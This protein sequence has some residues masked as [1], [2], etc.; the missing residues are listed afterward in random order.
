MAEWPSV[1][2]P[3]STS[4]GSQ[5]PLLVG[6]DDELTLIRS[7]LGSG[8]GSKHFGTLLVGQRGYGKTVILGKM[9]AEAIEHDW[10]VIEVNCSTGTALAEIEARARSIL[11]HHYGSLMGRIAARIKGGGISVL[12]TGAYVDIDLSEGGVTSFSDLLVTLGAAAK[13]KSQGVLLL[14]DEMHSLASQ[15]M[16]VLAATLQHVTNSLDYPV[17]YIGAGLPQLAE[18]IID[19]DAI[20]FFHRC[21]RL[22]LG[23]LADC[24]VAEGLSIPI[25]RYGGELTDRALEESVAYV[26]G[27]PYKLQMLGHHLWHVSAGV[28]HKITEEHLEVAKNRVD[29]ELD[30]HIYATI[31]KLVS[32]PGRNFVQAVLQ[33]GAT[34][35]LQDVQRLMKVAMND[36]NECKNELASHGL[37]EHDNGDWVSLTDLIPHNVLLRYLA[38]RPTPNREFAYSTAT[39]ES[40]SMRLAALSSAPPPVSTDLVCGLWMPRSRTYCVLPNGHKGRCRSHTP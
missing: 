23:A 21:D 22:V 24:D 5:P 38:R 10:P 36:V 25:A 18:I 31:W 40:A 30:K 28:E 27:Y 17:A 16:R 20:S 8:P 19:D 11:T 14:M 39:G 15:D 7:G 3:F 32:V 29:S 37:V 2:N 9:R 6:R 12:G 34:S 26:S 33:S 35:T 1:Q 4:F 13:E